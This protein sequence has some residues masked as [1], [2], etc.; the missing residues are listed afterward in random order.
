MNGLSFDLDYSKDAVQKISNSKE[1]F[2]VNLR[3][4]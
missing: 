1:T 2:E 3:I 4:K